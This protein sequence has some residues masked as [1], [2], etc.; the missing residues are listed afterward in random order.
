MDLF[1]LPDP[2]DGVS[3]WLAES[4]ADTQSTIHGD[5]NLEN[6]LIGPGGL[7]W[8]I[9]FAHLESE[10]VA[11]V[12]ALQA[13]HPGACLRRLQTGGYPLL[14]VVRDMATRCLFNPARP[15]EYRLAQV[16]ACLGALKYENLN[17]RQKHCLYLTAACLAQTL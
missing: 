2:L 7:V 11:H 3:T 4:M 16:M 13:D 8:L 9:D 1:G 12:L 15:R 14:D 6:V 5:L 10:I 17:S